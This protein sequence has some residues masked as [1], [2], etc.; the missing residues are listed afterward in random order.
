MQIKL[1]IPVFGV[2][3]T[4]PHYPFDDLRI[5]DTILVPHQRA[6]RLNLTSAIRKRVQKFPGKL[7]A[8]REAGGG[9][10]LIERVQ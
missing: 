6:G 10:W 7:F 3:G 4:K 8:V 1:P 2:P 9:D 5:G